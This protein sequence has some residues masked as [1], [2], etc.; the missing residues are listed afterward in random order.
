M[1]QCNGKD[2]FLATQKTDQQFGRSY[3]LGGKNT[4]IKIF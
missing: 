2:F 3:L 1:Q 4:D